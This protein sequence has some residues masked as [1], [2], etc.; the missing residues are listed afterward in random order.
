MKTLELIQFSALHDCHYGRKVEQTR[1]P[2]ESVAKSV[3]NRSVG[4]DP[5]SSLS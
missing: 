5:G 4:L 3:L 1:N 2:G